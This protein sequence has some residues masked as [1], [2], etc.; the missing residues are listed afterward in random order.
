MKKVIVFGTFDIF[1]KGHESFLRQ[2]RKYG[3]YLIVIIARNR[4]VKKVKGRAP[5]ND[6]K[7]RLIT[8]KKTGLTE[9]VVLGNLN[10]MYAQIKKYKPDVIGL[11]YDQTSFVGKLQEKI[12]SFGLK[13]TRIIRLKPFKPSIYKSSKMNQL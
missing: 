8:I 10:D 6:E 4:T 12:S 13:N 3:D 9:K 2:A 1:H 7:K 11:G 5:K